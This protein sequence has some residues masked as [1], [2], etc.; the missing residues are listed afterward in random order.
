MGAHYSTYELRE[1]AVRAV[2]RGLSISKV[3]A[4]YGTNRS[5][6]FRWVQRCEQEGKQGLLRKPGSG[7][8]R[9][10]EELSEMPF[11]T[12]TYLSIGCPFST[13]F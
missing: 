8:P 12:V 13:V 9:K 1:R 7:R 4:A 6:I 5:T 3:D 10:L 11:G 2:L